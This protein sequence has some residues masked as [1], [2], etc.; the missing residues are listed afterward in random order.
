MEHKLLNV[1]PQNCMACFESTSTAAFCCK[2]P[3]CKDCYLEWLKKRRQ[4]MHCKADQCPFEEWVTEYRTEDDDNDEEESALDI[5]IIELSIDETNHFIQELTEYTLLN[6]SNQSIQELI[7][8]VQRYNTLF[9]MYLDT[10]ST[11]N[12]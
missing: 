8:S 9:Q 10:H 7:D 11:R 1:D 12:S 4:C 5:E 3:I 2:A 6:L